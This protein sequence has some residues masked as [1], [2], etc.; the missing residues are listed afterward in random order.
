MKPEEAGFTGSIKI[1]TAV[2]ELTVRFSRSNVELEKFSESSNFNINGKTKN[3]FIWY[4]ENELLYRNED[5]KLFKVNF[6]PV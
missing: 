5:G 1:H 6:E 2:G 3:T 4:L